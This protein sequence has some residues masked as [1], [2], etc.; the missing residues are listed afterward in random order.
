MPGPPPD[1]VIAAIDQPRIDEPFALSQRRQVD[2]TVPPSNGDAGKDIAL[3]DAIDDGRPDRLAR[4]ISE[5]RP[6]RPR[7]GQMIV[8]DAA[9]RDAPQTGHAAALT[10]WPGWPRRTPS[11]RRSGAKRWRSRA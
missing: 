6:V 5:H 3:P 7:I 8:S 4:A 1:G 2:V 9:C 10:P 11:W